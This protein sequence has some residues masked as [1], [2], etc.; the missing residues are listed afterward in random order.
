MVEGIS[1]IEQ[2]RV[3]LEVDKKIHSS[4]I[5]PICSNILLNPIEC[6]IIKYHNVLE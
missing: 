2:E 3:V 6:V 5:C 4:L 1:K